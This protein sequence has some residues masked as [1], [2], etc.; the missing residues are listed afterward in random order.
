MKDLLDTNVLLRMSE[1]GTEPR[2]AC[3]AAVRAGPL[4]LPPLGA[5]VNALII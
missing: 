3:V 2:W 1:P 4:A 5:S